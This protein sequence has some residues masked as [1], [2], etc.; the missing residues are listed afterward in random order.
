MIRSI[1]AVVF[2]NRAIDDT[3]LELQD[4]LEASGFVCNA[5]M[6]AVAEHSLLHQFG[7]GR[8]D[9]QDE[10][11]LMGF[12]AK[13]MENIATQRTPEFPG[14]RPYRQ[15]FCHKITPVLDIKILEIQFHH[16]IEWRRSFIQYFPPYVGIPQNKPLR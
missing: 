1:L 15:Y 3:L 2:G 10:K 9:S 11:E 8:P 12:A 5:G 4:V 13:I 6:E 7:T 14:N 16:V